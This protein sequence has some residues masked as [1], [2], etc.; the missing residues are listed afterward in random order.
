VQAAYL[1][2]VPGHL[3]GILYVRLIS[4]LQANRLLMVGSAINLVVNIGLNLVFMRRY[5]VAGIALSTAAVYGVSC[6]YL[7]FV[8]HRQ[9]RVAEVVLGRTV[10]RTTKQSATNTPASPCTSVA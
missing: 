5:G 2:Q 8:A 10:E 7:A 4:A 9:L 3:L 1:L 6:V